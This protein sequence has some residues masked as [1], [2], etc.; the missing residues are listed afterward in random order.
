VTV[1]LLPVQS[2]GHH[3]PELVVEWD[4]PVIVVDDGS[5]PA[6]APVLREAAERGAEVLRHDRNRGKGVAL[7]T[8]FRHIRDRHPGAD[9]VC[10]DADGQHPPAD[11]RRVGE[12]VAETRRMTLG[13]RRFTGDVP[14]RSRFGNR[15]TARLF[16]VATGQDIGDTQTGLRGYPADQ[17]EWLSAIEGERFEYEMNVLTAAARRGLPIDQV[18]IATIY[19]GSSQFGALADSARIYWSL[20]RV[21]V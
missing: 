9:V 19:N 20:L 18:E 4:A 13:V 10:A 6:S 21:L 1:L 14:L 12:H 8:G 11:I 7:K 5:E 2:P 15:L 3:L 16:R 17:L